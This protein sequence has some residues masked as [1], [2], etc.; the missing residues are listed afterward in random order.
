LFVA[1]QISWLAFL[2]NF[3]AAVPN[4]AFV[5]ISKSFKLTV[6]QASYELTVYIIFA[7]IGPFLITPIA[8]VYGR[9]PVYLAGN[10]LAGLCNVIA[11]FVGSWSGLLVTRVFC[12]IGSGAAA[13]IGAAT[14]CDLY[15]MHERG[16]YMGVFT[17]FLT[18]GAHLAPLVGGYIAE[19]LG[20]KYCF[21]IPGYIQLATLALN[22]VSLPETLYSRKDQLD[23]KEHS[24]LDLL[25]FKASRLTD[26]KLYFAD[27]L[28]PF[29][30][31]KYAAIIIPAIYYMT[32]F[33]Y[34]TVLF[35][36]TGSSIFTKL[37][38]FNVAQTGLMLSI[39][40]TIGCL[41]GEASAGW[42]TDYMVYLYAKRHEGHRKPEPR[43]NALLLALLLPL[44][45]I[46]DGVCLQ[47]H[48][49]IHWIGPAFGMGIACFG[50]QVATTVTYSYCT[51]VSC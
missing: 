28:R 7:G 8:N 47:R 32:A 45:V 38:H 51:D 9:R 22:L 37:Y 23:H 43:L 4:P 50:L 41:I 40:L 48:A 29:Y 16:F 13:S 49:T 26:R 36:T 12:G 35:A 25:L 3:A 17:L 27:F 6:V 24:Y 33:A 18:N 20:W 11:G 5:S 21:S 10:L 2:G 44:G 19:D 30:M 39:P 46:I 31:L 1:L 34:G 14:I 42:V 15:F